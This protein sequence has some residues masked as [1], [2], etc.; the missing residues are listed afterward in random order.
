M[1]TKPVAL[2]VAASDPSGGAGIQADLKTFS[3]FNVH[4]CSVLTSLTVQN[5]KSVDSIFHL[6]ATFVQEQLS[7]LVSDIKINAIKIGVVGNSD[8]IS[9]LAD[10]I[11]DMPSNF[12]IVI[13]PVLA[14]TK[15]QNFLS[16][17]AENMLKKQLIPL[18]TLLTPNIIEA[19]QLLSFSIPESIEDVEKM[20]DPLMD[21]GCQSVLVKGG[22]MLENNNIIDVYYDGKKIYHLPN[23]RLQNAN[24]HG[25][26]CVLSSAI[27]AELAKN[28][29]ILNAIHSAKNYLYKLMVKSQKSI[30]GGSTSLLD[31]T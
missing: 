30:I 22:H 27:T 28:T 7:Y 29:E 24:Y 16:S 14:P 31:F 5:S 8:I 23:K 19:S 21:L 13:D 18:A 15:G 4:G 9:R 6:P 1:I 2:S 20:L 10:F 26:G 12:K 3:A 25:T 11:R 17:D